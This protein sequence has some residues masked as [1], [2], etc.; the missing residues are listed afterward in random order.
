MVRI[1]RLFIL[2][3][4]LSA[5]VALASPFPAQD[6]MS[7]GESTHA[8]AHAEVEPTAGASNQAAAHGKSAHG[9]SHM[10][11]RMMILV[12]QLGIL[13]L[14]A[15]FCGEVF[16]RYLKQPAV[17]GELCAGMILGPHALGP[18]IHLP[19]GGA[20]F[21]IFPNTMGIS[22]ELYGVATLASIILLFMVGL[23]TDFKQFIRYAGPGLAVGLG[24][25]L[26]SFVAGD[27]IY[28]VMVGGKFMDPAA[29][30]MGTVSTATSVGITAR[31]LSEKKKLDSP[32]GTTILAG[33]VIDDVLG[34]LIL[35]VVLG[36]AAA[37]QSGDQQVAWGKIGLIA[38]KAVGFWLGATVLGILASSRIA[39]FM[40]WFRTS[41]SIVGLGF[42]MALLLAG[43]AETFGL[44]MI[45]GAYIM[46]LSLS[47]E[48]ISHK[49]ER[50]LIPVYAC[51][52]PI[53]FA[54]MG[55]LVDFSAMGT[56]LS[57]G[58]V[59]TALA[60]LAKIAGSGIPAL[61]VGFNALGA[62]RIG[63]GMLPRGE[64]ALIVAG[65]GM[66]ANFLEPSMFGVIIMMTL[67]TTVVAPPSLV[68]LFNRKSSGLSR[69]RQAQSKT[70]SDVHKV[71]LIDSLTWTN[72]DL[73][74]MCIQNAFETQQFS[75]NIL[76]AD[77]GIYQFSG[78]IGEE[79]IN[80]TL[81]DR[82]D[83][84][85]I[86]TQPEHHDLVRKLVDAAVQDAHD[87]IAKL[88]VKEIQLT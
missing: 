34:I 83:R 12:L 31:V 45:I 6:G 75:V 71:I 37:G 64:V 50:S 10:P 24:G 58:L 29:L 21:D 3:L 73:L 62:A 48:H 65:I 40:Y 18:F 72:H 74:L 85:E 76:N 28:V 20:L 70:R 9:E 22:P 2:I 11:H 41:G 79:I 4:S 8:V 82:M 1:L 67:I 49:L 44:A 46:G 81:R 87:R 35:A 66:G 32:E 53:F 69:K 33:A 63:L 57:F 54:V 30:F 42:G 43:I 17:L 59:Y 47:K 5:W 84:I 27:L 25:V 26:V 86:K 16:E 61:F 78:E 23:E 15:R 19:G 80:V 88:Q 55:M 7:I 39:A 14:A 36:I 52:V 51:M 60:I 13:V 56:A 38:F 77:D 68:A